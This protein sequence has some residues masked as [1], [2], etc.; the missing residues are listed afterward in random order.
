MLAR[1][2]AGQ[3]LWAL[4]LPGAILLFAGLLW[5]RQEPTEPALPAW[6]FLAPLSYYVTLIAVIGYVYDRFLLPVTTIL[7]LVAAIGVRKT[8]GGRGL[9]AVALL[10]WLAWRAASVDALLVRDSRY[11]AEAW[12]RAHVPRD[13]WVVS[14]DE[15]GYVPRLD[16]FRHREIAATIEET[17]SSRP[18]FIVVNTEFLARS[19][20]D[21]PERLWL[22]WLQTDPGPYEVAFRYKAPLGWSALAWHARFRDRREDDFTNLDKANPEIVIFRRR[23]DK[24]PG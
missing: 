7:A 22:D 18:D 3:L 1:V 10:G 21:S 24:P 13:A 15:F 4:G 12:L 6:V 23:P 11:A 20:A 16:R 2:T 5:R 9:A 8:A 14:V 17:L 19:A